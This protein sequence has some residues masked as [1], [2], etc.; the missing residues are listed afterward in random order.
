M[1]LNSFS[2]QTDLLFFFFIHPKWIVLWVKVL[3]NFFT[4]IVSKCLWRGFY[5]V[6]RFR[7]WAFNVVFAYTIEPR[8]YDRRFNDW[9]PESTF[10]DPSMNIFPLQQLTIIRLGWAKYRDLSVASR[11]IICPSLRLQQIIHLRDNDKSHSREPSSIIVYP[12]ITE[13]VFLFKWISSG[14]EAIHK[15]EKSVV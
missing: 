12:S 14:S 5:F 6:W 3:K 4:K 8:F 7:N 11:P 1:T 10:R 13:F 9:F 15:K 2:Y